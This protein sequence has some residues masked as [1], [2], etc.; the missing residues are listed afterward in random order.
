MPLPE[1]VVEACAQFRQGDLVDSIPAL[2][3]AD[4]SRPLTP[5]AEKAAEAAGEAGD[6]LIV[7]PVEIPHDYG[8]IVSQTCDIRSDT[9]PTIKVAPVLELSD[10]QEVQ[11]RKRR[12]RREGEIADVKRGLRVHRVLLDG[13]P[14]YWYADLE[15]ITTIEKS[16]LLGKAATGGFST[17]EGYRD[18]A[19]RC[20]HV[21]DR[22]AVPDEVERPVLGNLRAFLKAKK[23]ERGDTFTLLNSALDEEALWLDNWETP[24]QAQLWFL[25]EEE[26]PD[27]VKEILDEWRQTLPGLEDVAVLP[28]RF[29]AF[30]AVNA[31]EYRDLRV[32]SYWYLSLDEESN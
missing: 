21:H 1:D 6:E 8:I 3:L 23:E 19:F 17:P 22:P 24:A 4:L 25:G 18:F 9:R 5:G 26:P 14:G 32:I 16:L 2:H 30:D 27:E 13:P 12:A 31:A 11:S 10:P 28:N 7:E 20:G 15:Q 29:A